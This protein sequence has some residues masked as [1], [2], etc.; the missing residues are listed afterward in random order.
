MHERN[1]VLVA[2][3]TGAISG[4]VILGLAGRA[5]MAVVAAAV[6]LP[7]NLSA[8]GVPEV[9]AVGA[10]LGAAGGLAVLLAR[11]LLPKSRAGRIVL[12]AATLFVFSVIRGHVDW[13]A[14]GLVVPTLATAAVVFLV[15]AAGE[16]FLVDRYASPGARQG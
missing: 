15:Y 1:P 10:I 14:D 4:A 13:S 2:L 6:G 5:A 9:V 11:K 8:P 7:A 16:D 3:A 12:V